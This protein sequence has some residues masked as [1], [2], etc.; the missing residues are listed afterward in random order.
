MEALEVCDFRLI[1]GVRQRLEA[2]GDELGGPA[3][4]HGLLAEKVGFG[5]FA[6]AGFDRSG[7]RSADARRIGQRL[8]ARS[9]RRILMD[10][11]QARDA[12]P[13]FIFTAD[14]VSGALRR[15]QDDIDVGAR[16]DL[17]R[18]R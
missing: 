10:R 1:A 11:E 12:A 17:A 5:L 6:E 16:L 2:R 18:A 8:V 13:D 7:A 3:A 4:K 14:E 15:N 9:T